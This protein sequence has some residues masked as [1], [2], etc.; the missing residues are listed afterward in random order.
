MPSTLSGRAYL[1]IFKLQGTIGGSFRFMFRDFE[2]T[3]LCGILQQLR[4]GS[5]HLLGKYHVRLPTRDYLV[6]SL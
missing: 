1:Y 6:L 3:R 5:L 4:Q 2:A